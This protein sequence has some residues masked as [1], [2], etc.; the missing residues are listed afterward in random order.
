[1]QRKESAKT[2]RA[3]GM[4]RQPAYQSYTPPSRPAVTE[5]YDTY[6][7]EKNKS[8]YVRPDYNYL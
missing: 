5:T 7:A 3:G 4:P 1:M 6:E 2:A 8:K